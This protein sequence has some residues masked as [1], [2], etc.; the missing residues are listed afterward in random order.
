MVT[1]VTAK[2]NHYETLGLPPTASTEE[3]G[4]AYAAQMTTFRLRPENALTRLAMLSTA[5]E[6]LRD[7]AK[8]R[9]YDS[10]LGLNAAPSAPKPVVAERPATFIG[11]ATAPQFNRPRPAPVTQAPEVPTR[12]PEPDPRVGSFIAASLRQPAAKSDSIEW[13]VVRPAEAAKPAP[14][15]VY[16]ELEQ[17]EEQARIH[18]NQAM[19]GAGII[20][21][22]ALGIATALPKPNV[23]RL[24]APT[25]H[26]QQAV[27]VSV[28]PATQAPVSALG[29]PIEASAKAPAAERQVPVEAAATTPAVETPVAETQSDEGA[30]QQAAADPLAPVA[31]DKSAEPT[32]DASA[33]TSAPGAVPAAAEAAT[34]VAAA[35]PLAS[36]TIA[37]TIRR[38]GYPCGSVSSTEAV[39]SASGV[40]KV[41]CSSGDA[42]QATPLH[43]RYHFRRL[44]SH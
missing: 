44:G 32:S 15:P 12:R 37:S 6:T 10:A 27:T 31:T 28:P 22:A 5:Y 29:A 11:V 1:S 23:D 30:A 16:V 2:S 40:F 9:A 14:A 21:L 13:P 20:G 17:E 36:A 38:I 18:K 26:A 24:A 33:E 41:T 25:V 3:I 19:I 39:G 8:R 43:G 4:K 42:Y 35:M 34:K 7:P